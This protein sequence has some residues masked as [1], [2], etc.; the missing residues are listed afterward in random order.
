MGYL[1]QTKCRFGPRLSSVIEEKSQE[2]NDK[3]NINNFECSGHSFT[4]NSQQKHK[5]PSSSH[6][7]SFKFKMLEKYEPSVAEN[8]TNNKVSDPKSVFNKVDINSISVRKFNLDGCEEQPQV[9]D[10]SNQAGG[11]E[12]M[13]MRVC[14]PIFTQDILD[15]LNMLD[16]NSSASKSLKSVNF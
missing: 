7:N 13:V 14:L 4:C 8:Q 16:L 2:E 9:F 15:S 11:Q 5:S 12:K 6:Q 3:L 1:S 10:F